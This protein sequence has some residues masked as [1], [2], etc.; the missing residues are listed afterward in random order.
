[1]KRTALDRLWT[2]PG[3]TPAQLRNSRVRIVGS[4]ILL[5]GVLIGLAL[6]LLR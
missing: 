6:V 2:P 4:M 1:V 3:R 5:A